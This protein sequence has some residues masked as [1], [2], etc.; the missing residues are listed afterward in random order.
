[1]HDIL[2]ILNDEMKELGANNP[3][4]YWSVENNSLGEAALIVID[5][6]DEDKFPESFYTNQRKEEYKKQSEKDLQ[7]HTK[8]KLQ[9]V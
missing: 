5:E 7:H 2:S 9:H 8:Q 6:M 1:M 4:I 3:E